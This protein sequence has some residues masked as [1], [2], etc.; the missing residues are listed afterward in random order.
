MDRDGSGSLGLGELRAL[1]V[2]MNVVITEKELRRKFDKFDT[3]KDGEL[4]L[5][6]FHEFFR[7]V[8]DKPGPQIDEVRAAREHLPA[9]APSSAPPDPPLARAGRSCPIAR[10]R[11]PSMPGPTGPCR[12]TSSAP[13]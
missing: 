1:L 5:E 13:S 10:R 11:L 7:A 6:E 8:N 9:P 3:S 2:S 4:D 12:P